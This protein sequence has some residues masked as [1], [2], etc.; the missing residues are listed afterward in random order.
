MPKAKGGRFFVRFG[1]RKRTYV[2]I[3]T[4]F[5]GSPLWLWILWID[6]ETIQNTWT[7]IPFAGVVAYAGAFGMSLMMWKYFAPHRKR[8]ADALGVDYDA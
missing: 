3:S 8:V 6:R 5:M 2:T 1:L 4:I 7:L